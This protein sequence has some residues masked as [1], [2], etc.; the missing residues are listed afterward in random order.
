MRIILGHD[1]ALEF[2]GCFDVLDVL[3]VEIRESVF[4]GRSHGHRFLDV[5]ILGLK[6]GD[7]V[8]D[9]GALFELRT[10]L[11][12]RVLWEHGF[13]ALEDMCAAVDRAEGHVSECAGEGLNR[14]IRVECYFSH[15]GGVF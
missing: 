12:G 8:V 4:D 6:D 2:S 7:A 10:L 13:F 9:D 15:S 5:L 3:F 1:G 11:A 14:L